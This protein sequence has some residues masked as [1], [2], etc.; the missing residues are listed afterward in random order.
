MF[1]TDVED[2]LADCIL[3]PDEI[4]R[5]ATCHSGALPSIL[6]KLYHWLLT[7]PYGGQV[8]GW[9]SPKTVWPA[10]PRRYWLLRENFTGCRST[11]WLRRS[12]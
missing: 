2:A 1:V 3:S 11:G 12:E 4:G 10:F 9:T 8:A 5:D 7:G 6:R